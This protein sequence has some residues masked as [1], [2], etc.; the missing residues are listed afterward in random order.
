MTYRQ[1]NLASQETTTLSTSSNSSPGKTPGQTV[2]MSDEAELQRLAATH[3]IGVPI[4]DE[5]S[6]V[7]EMK[8]I[9]QDLGVS[10]G[11][12]NAGPRTTE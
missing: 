4:F 10:D 3:G 1:M 12:D 2:S 8:E 7:D 11:N 5:Y 9:L 6:D